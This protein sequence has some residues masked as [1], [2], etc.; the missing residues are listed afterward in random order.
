MA[1]T[2]RADPRAF[3][4]DAVLVEA[5]V[6]KGFTASIIRNEQPV[7]AAMKQAMDEVRGFYGAK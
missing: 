6:K 5:I 2:A 1:D 3:W 4:K 7:A